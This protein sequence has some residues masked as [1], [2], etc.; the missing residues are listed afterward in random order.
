MRFKFFI[1]AILALVGWVIAGNKIFSECS[2]VPQSDQIS[3]SWIT[4][5]ETNISAFIVLRSNDSQ[6]Y[7]VLKNLNAKGPGTQYEYID[8]NVIFKSSNKLFYKVR[9]VDKNNNLIEESPGLIV[10]TQ[11]S[12]I[13]QTWGAIKAIFK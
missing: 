11:L 12:D 5:S 2:A 13:H 8:E 1:I 6:H 7:V 9:A 4:I 3:I 10:Q